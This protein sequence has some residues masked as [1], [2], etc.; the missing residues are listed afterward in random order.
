MIAKPKLIA[1]T[2]RNPYF[3]DEERASI[4]LSG[5]KTSGFMIRQILDAHGGILPSWVKVTFANTGL[6]ME[7]TLVF[8]QAMSDNWGFDITWLEIDE[9][10]TEPGKNGKTK[11]PYT[12]KVVDFETAARSGEPFAKIIKQ[13][14]SLPNPV[15]RYCSNRMKSR[16]FKKY[17]NSIGWSDWSSYLGIRADEHRRGM[18]MKGKVLEGGEIVLP[19]MDAGHT[20]KDVSQFWENNDFDLMLPTHGGVAALGNCSLCFLKNGGKK[21]SIIR[22]RPDLADWW[23]EQESLAGQVADGNGRFFR[24]DQPTYATMKSAAR[25][26]VQMFEFDDDEIPC[27]CGD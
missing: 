25:N 15:N 17:L 11:R 27:Y 23:I 24:I 22:E 9:A 18:K 13:H 5:G 10:W 8:V 4:S 7:E 6:E 12:V 2:K 21:Q 1:T 19:M 20:I 3:I 26:Q 16:A 14:G